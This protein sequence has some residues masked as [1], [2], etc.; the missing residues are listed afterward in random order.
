MVSGPGYAAKYLETIVEFS[1]EGD[2]RQRHLSNPG[3]IKKLHLDE[4]IKEERSQDMV[5]LS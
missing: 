5:K 2:Q 3:P 1:N 4:N